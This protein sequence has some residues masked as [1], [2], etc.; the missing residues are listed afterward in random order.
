MASQQAPRLA[1]P[2][3]MRNRQYCV[4]FGTT[5][6]TTQR[7]SDGALCGYQMTCRWRNVR[8]GARCAKEAS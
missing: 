5:S 7:W 2:L 6:W 1:A 8:G 4:P 3:H